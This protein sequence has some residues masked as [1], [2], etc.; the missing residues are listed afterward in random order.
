M[1]FVEFSNGWLKSYLS[2]CNQYLSI[3]GCES[4]FATINCDVPQ[5][6][7]PRPILFLL[8]T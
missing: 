7:I 4:D 3:T 2:N 6:S 1:G 5:G 8:Y